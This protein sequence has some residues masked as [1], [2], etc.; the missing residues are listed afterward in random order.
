MGV[1]GSS[2]GASGVGLAPGAAGGAIGRAGVDGSLCGV[3]SPGIAGVS[4]VI[5]SATGESSSSEELQAASENTSVAARK[6]REVKPAFIEMSCNEW[7]SGEA[8]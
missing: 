6:Y 5:P 3:S 7:D 2:I 4:G 8:D 1:A